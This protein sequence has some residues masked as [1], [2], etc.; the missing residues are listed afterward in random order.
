MVVF[1]LWRGFHCEIPE[2]ERQK[3]LCLQSEGKRKMRC[4][5][6]KTHE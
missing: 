5:H 4:C 2:R 6:G 3:F 1:L